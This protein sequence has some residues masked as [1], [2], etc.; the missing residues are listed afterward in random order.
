MEA[1]NFSPEEKQRKG[2]SSKGNSLQAAVSS[3]ATVTKKN[4][5]AAV[6]AVA[7][8][9]MEEIDQRAA[10]TAQLGTRARK[11]AEDQGVQG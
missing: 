1:D 11:P 7:A 8:V 6:A 9:Q 3:V 5:Q 10:A 4:L 2:Y